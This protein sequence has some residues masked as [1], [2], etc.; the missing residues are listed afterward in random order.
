MHLKVIVK[1]VLQKLMFNILNIKYDAIL[2]MFWLYDRNFKINWVNKK[3]CAIKCTYKISEQSKM[4]LSEYKLWNYEILLLK[5]E[6]F[7]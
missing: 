7:R 3:L 6:Q 1:N 5:K 4:Y 2:E